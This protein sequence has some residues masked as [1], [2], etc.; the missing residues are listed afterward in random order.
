MGAAAAA[1]HVSTRTLHRRLAV[2]GTSYRR[3]IDTARHARAV[4]MLSDLGLG[5]DQIAARLGY[6]D[7][8]AFIRAFRRW[9]GATPVPTERGQYATC[10]GPVHEATRPPVSLRETK[11]RQSLHSTGSSRRRDTCAYAPDVPASA[12]LP[13]ETVLDQDLS[14]RSCEPIKFPQD[15]SGCT[16]AY[17]GSIRHP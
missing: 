2:E 17:G 13:A 1:L 4:E 7:A 3:L 6:A 12:P 14:D 16:P 10:R 8:A 5:V 11:R 9:T 15:G